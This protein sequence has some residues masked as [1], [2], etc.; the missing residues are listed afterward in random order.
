MADPEFFAEEWKESL[1]L[2]MTDAVGEAYEFDPK[3]TLRVS[4]ASVVSLMFVDIAA[5]C[6]EVLDNECDD[7]DPDHEQ[8]G[9][10]RKLSEF[11]RE[12]A[13]AMPHMAR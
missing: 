7:S 4:M 10:A 2:S 11:L 8:I 13:K 5:I 12:L 9:D 3:Q 6:D 1:V